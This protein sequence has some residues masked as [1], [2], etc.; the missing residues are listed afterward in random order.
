M[1]YAN[2]QIKMICALSVSILTDPLPL[3]DNCRGGRNKNRAVKGC[4]A[5]LVKHKKQVIDLV[6]SSSEESSGVDALRSSATKKSD[7][8][9]EASGN[10]DVYTVHGEEVKV[11]I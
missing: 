6:S 7:K 3:L 11:F 4:E 2:K 8:K 5:P 10:T 1:I 9:K